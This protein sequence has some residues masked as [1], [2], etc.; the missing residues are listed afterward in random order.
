[1]VKYWLMA[2]TFTAVVA[3]VGYLDALAR[4]RN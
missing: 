3:A 4:R 2:L 1:V